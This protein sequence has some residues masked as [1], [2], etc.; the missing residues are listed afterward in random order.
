[1]CRFFNWVEWLPP[2][3]CISPTNSRGYIC[4]INAYLQIK[5]DEK[6]QKFLTVNTHKGLYKYKRLHFGIKLAP[7]IFQQIMNKML[8]GLDGVI[9][10][11]DDILIKSC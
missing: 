6:C 3:K 11:I 9:A 1:M 7:G 8:A 5:V 2:T 10:Y 4:Q